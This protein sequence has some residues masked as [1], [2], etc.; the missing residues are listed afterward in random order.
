M[1]VRLRLPDSCVDV[2]GACILLVS[3]MV[4]RLGTRCCTAW[5]GPLAALS[6]I[7]HPG[8]QACGQ[9]NCKH[10]LIPA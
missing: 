3:A 10:K 9:Y 5:C 6:R 2:C 8:L 4:Q 1:H 7:L